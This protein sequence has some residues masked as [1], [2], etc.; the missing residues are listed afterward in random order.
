MST[1]N[2]FLTNPF[3]GHGAFVI[4][5]SGFPKIDRHSKV[6]ASICEVSAPQ[7]E[8]LDFPFIGA[9]GMHIRNTVPLDNGTVS[10]WV[11]VDWDRDI[12]LR[13]TIYVSND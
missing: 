5:I 10:F 6:I 11:Q 12:N 8:P 3:R 1:V 13:M 4:N 7:G 9:A 2:T